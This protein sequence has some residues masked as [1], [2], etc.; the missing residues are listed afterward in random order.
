[1]RVV[2]TGGGTGG[3]IYPA[4]A[5]ARMLRENHPDVQLLYIG[6]KKGLERELVPREQIPFTFIEVEGLRRKLS[7]HA[8]K[9][10]WMA[11]TSIVAASRIIARFRPDVVIGTGGYVVVPV[12]AAAHLRGVRTGILELDAQAGLA[13]RLVYRFADTVML[14]MENK[15]NTFA[16]A[17][18]VVLT[19]NPRASEV[20]SLPAD[21]KK[22]CQGELGLKHGVP[23]VTIVSGSRGASPINQVVMNWLNAK[24]S[25]TYQVV[26]ITGQVHYDQVI[27][28]FGTDTLC[29]GMVKVVAFYHNMPALLSV[30]SILVS[31]AGATTLAEVTA[32]GVPSVLIPSPYVTHR[33]QDVNASVLVEREAAILLAEQ[34]LTASS[35]EKQIEGLIKN[36]FRLEAMAKAS[37]SLGKTDALQRIDREIQRLAV[38]A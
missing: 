16:K 29:D 28:Q 27:E 37:R 1:M 22:I 3:H 25:L 35:L 36:P 24:P 2:L 11:L 18:H 38:M 10:A 34:D 13:N 7:L 8:F 9:T 19:G 14:G 20:A 33:H 5:I 15:S 21:A 31:R 4:L 26:W 30:T 17:K 32:L 6:T 23:I 12:I